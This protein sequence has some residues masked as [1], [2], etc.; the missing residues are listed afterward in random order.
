MSATE[1]AP[2]CVGTSVKRKED[3]SLLRGQGSGHGDGEKGEK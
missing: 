3:A 1:T 2:G